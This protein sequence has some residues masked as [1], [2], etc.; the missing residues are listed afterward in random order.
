M[1][2]SRTSSNTWTAWARIAR[3]GRRAVLLCATSST[4][5]GALSALARRVAML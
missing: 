2:I 4:R 5:Y 3:P 1:I